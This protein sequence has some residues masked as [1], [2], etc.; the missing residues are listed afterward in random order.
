MREIYSNVTIVGGGLI[1]LATAYAL[2]KLGLTV[3]VLEKKLLSNQKYKKNDIRTVAISEG[4]KDFLNKLSIWEKL[5]KHA[6]PIKKIKVVDRKLTNQLNFDNLRRK[7]N[8]GY[9]VKNQ[10]ILNI[11]YKEIFRKKNIKIFDNIKIKRFETFNKNSII[12]TEK[13]VFKSDLIIAA[14]GKKSLIKN[15]TKQTYFEKNYNKTALVANITHSEDHKNIAYEFFL[16]NGP[17]A[18]LPMQKENKSYVSSIVWTN[19]NK[20]LKSLLYSDNKNLITV[21]NQK[22]QGTIGNI[23]EILSKQ[24]FPLSAHLNTSFFNN[25]LIFIGDSAHSFHPIAGQGWNLGMK[26]IESLFNIV[27]KYQYLGIDIGTKIFCKEYHESTF[28]RAFRLYQVTDKLD[29][30]FRK[31]NIVFNF[32][33]SSGINL[34]Q[35]NPKIKNM[36]SDFAMGL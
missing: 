28:Y 5:E 21:L 32:L 15:L 14:D 19:E 1:G 35:R 27:K 24:T 17:L 18:I 30:T 2:S 16:K 8:L 4:T 10:S 6:E 23:T 22:T 7:S 33:R 12:L 9:I 20:F 26:D 13:N 3:V 29:K 34:L 25:N 36:I 31:N 11:F